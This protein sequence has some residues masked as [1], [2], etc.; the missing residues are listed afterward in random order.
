MID[1]RC[2]LAAYMD[3][4]W[5]AYMEFRAD[6]HSPH[7]RS[8]QNRSKDHT[9]HMTAQDLSVPF[10]QQFI[11]DVASQAI[12]HNSSLNPHQS[13]PFLHQTDNESE[14]ET[15]NKSNSL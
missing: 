4:V 14:R 3:G 7:S 2:D 11:A 12:I 10:L 15:R 9:L 6:G 13:P 8:L 1:D 5:E